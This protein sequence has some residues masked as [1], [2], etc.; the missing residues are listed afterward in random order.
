M[1]K[2][3][4]LEKAVRVKASPGDIIDILVR[5]ENPKPRKP[6]K[7]ILLSAKAKKEKQIQERADA[8]RRRGN[9][10]ELRLLV[11]LCIR[12]AEKPHLPERQ[13]CLQCGLRAAE[14]NRNNQRR[15][16][17]IH[18]EERKNHQSKT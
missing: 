11:G 4:S 8:R 5:R 12:C 15:K 13:M 7:R 1:P 14:L 10:R 3:D 17:T 9:L 16:R 6:R 2:N 18:E